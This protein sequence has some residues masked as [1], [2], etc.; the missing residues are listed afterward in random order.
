MNGDIRATNG[1]AGEAGSSDLAGRSAPWRRI[2]VSRYTLTTVCV[3]LLSW[4]SLSLQVMDRSPA[5]LSGLVRRGCVC[6]AAF[7]ICELARPILLKARRRPF[8]VQA[9]AGLAMTLVGA[10]LYGLINYAAFYIVFPLAKAESPLLEGILPAAIAQFFVF[11]VWSAVTFAMVHDD[12]ARERATRLLSAQKLAA[13]SQMAMLRYQLNPHFLFNSL[14]ALSALIL[15]RENDK[16]EQFVLS[17]SAFLR[18]S[19]SRE[20]AET[21]PL[22]RELQIQREYLSL[23]ETRF[24][25]RLR[26]VEDIDPAAAEAATPSL[27]LQPLVENAIKHGVAPSTAPVT[28]TISARR[29]GERLRVSVEDDAPRSDGAAAAKLGVGLENV[30]RRLE[31]LYGDEASLTVRR[32]DQAGFQATL[33]L[34]FRTSVAAADGGLGGRRKPPSF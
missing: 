29:A 13:E 9:L 32:N 8:G 26:V 23:E 24:P 33:E 31:V 6:L 11:M 28:L 27:I 16:A 18:D 25:D 12:E 21:I 22:D 1:A 19:L 17:L 14:N 10:T 30:R 5:F 7:V 2:G 4:A 20:V 3:W 15:A 34:P